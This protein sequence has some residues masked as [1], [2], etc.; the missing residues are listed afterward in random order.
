MNFQI[1]L[2][3]TLT[4]SLG[5]TGC[6]LKKPQDKPPIALAPEYPGASANEGASA[7]TLEWHQIFIDPRLQKLIELALNNNQDLRIAALNVEATRQQ[8]R[9]QRAE[10]YPHVG[11]SGSY[12]RSNA[13]ASVAVAGI[14][15]NSGGQQTS[16][17]QYGQYGVNAAL[18]SYEIDLF[19]RLRA[20]SSAAS[21][22]YLASE[23][24][25]RAA[26]IS[27]IA[28]VADAH[29]AERLVREQL[30]LTEKTLSN[31]KL[32]L[33]ITQK[34]HGA[35]QAS[36][37]EVEQARGLVMQVEVDLE[38][39]RRV[40]QRA[41]DALELLV[42]SQLPAD[43]PQGDSLLSQ[44]TREQLPAGLPSDLLLLRPDVRAAEHDLLA[45]HAN[46]SAARAA[47]FPRISLTGAIGLSSLAFGGLFDVDNQ[48][49]SYSPQ[50]TQPIFQAGQLKGEY[51]LSKLRESIQ[52]VTYEKVVRTAFREVADGLAGR[53]TYRQQLEAQEAAVASAHHRTALSDRRYRAGASD[54]LELL[55][56]QR[57]EYTAEQTFL[58][59][60]AE[61]Y[62][63][64]TQL[65]RV[66]GGGA[67]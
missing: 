66:L 31:W 67:K 27:L 39:R 59:L 30:A 20:L 2:V 15:G 47:F 55:D 41:M 61:S 37:V 49:W 44:Q 38:N 13:P 3:A 62:S 21:E 28:G 53:A 50:I 35:G 19:G 45:A 56:S 52:I 63:N 16:S 46:V 26:Q 10:Q 29:F 58:E 33:A 18:S 8:L 43:L 54:R 11:A 7:A 23:E 51:R 1:F 40:L 14:G 17:F 65:Y 12:Q 6:A 4:L 42:G 25:R 57:S 22:R 64:I 60:K 32:S 36:G 24:N 5:L 34:R 48:N 9:I